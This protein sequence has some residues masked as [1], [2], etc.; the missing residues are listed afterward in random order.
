MKKE[1]FEK[2]IIREEY[3]S[4]GL[5]FSLFKKQG[6]SKTYKG[7]LIQKMKEARTKGNFEIVLLIQH[8]YRKYL[9]FESHEKVLLESWKGKSGI[10]LIR[11]PQSF[12]V[13]THQKSEKDSDP[14]EIKTE[15]DYMEIN[16]IIKAMNE[17]D[18]DEIP[19]KEIGEKAYKKRW[20]D[21]FSNRKQHIQ[22]TFIFN[23]LEHL[24]II[25]YY[26]SGKIKKLRKIGEIQSILK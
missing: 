2:N 13:V 3:Y 18:N 19:T 14:K 8:F 26:R 23:I 15:I 6:N 20:D 11:K 16:K 1:V 24:G 21:I 22:L 25:K 9:E 7:Y 4:N 12:I 5:D 17:I 10:H